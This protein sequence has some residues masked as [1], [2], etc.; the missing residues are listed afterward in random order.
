MAGA[1]DFSRAFLYRWTVNWRML[2]PAVFAAP[3]FHRALLGAHISLL[4]AFL[5]W[6]WCR[7]YGGLLRMV[8]DR[9]GTR[10]ASSQRV[11]LDHTLLVL[12][13]C[14]LIGVL[15]A[16]SLH[17]QFYAW[18]YHA[19]PYLLARARW[20]SMAWW[21]RRVPAWLRASA[22]VC[23]RLGLLACIEWCWNVFPATPLSSSVLLGAHLVLLL[24]L[25]GTG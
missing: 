3:A 23:G 17:Y 2:S 19:L 24:G 18:Y 16:R 15:C 7:P 22:G 20:G 6:R 4:L 21:D 10:S 12:G 13:T 11:D 5:C 9:L 14:N 25:W 1:F 8:R